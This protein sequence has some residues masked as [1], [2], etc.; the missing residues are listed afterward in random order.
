MKQRA[1]EV[2]VTPDGRVQIEAVGFSGPDCEKATAFLEQALGNAGP[3]HR[4]IE[5]YARR[6]CT[7]RQ[8]VGS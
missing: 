2:V 4:K 8:R 6:E 3:R 7:P 1:I 5:Y